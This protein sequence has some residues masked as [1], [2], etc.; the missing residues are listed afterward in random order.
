MPLF[1]RDI[2]YGNPAFELS[3]D[4]IATVL[5]IVCRG[6]HT[7]RPDVT[8]GMLEVPLTRIVRKGMKRVKSMLGITNPER[9]NNFETLW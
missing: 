3:E 9:V 5:D 1:A 8:P 6:A 7:A 2:P 4:Q